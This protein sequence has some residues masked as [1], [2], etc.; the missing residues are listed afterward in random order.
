MN[1]ALA[2]VRIRPST[3]GKCANSRGRQVGDSSCHHEAQKVFTH[4]LI[5]VA[6]RE[7]ECIHRRALD[8]HI[9]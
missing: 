7:S 1:V 4:V 3:Q 2:N 6:V 5:I 8:L 9:M